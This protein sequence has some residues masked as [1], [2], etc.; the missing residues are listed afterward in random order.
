MPASLES[1]KVGDVLIVS[2]GGNGF[3]LGRVT[4][5]TK[6]QVLTGTSRWRKKD[7]YAVGGDTW[8][9]QSARIPQPGEIERLEDEKRRRG[10]CR[11]IANNAGN[12]SDSAL[13]TSE[14]EALVGKLRE[15]LKT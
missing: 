6:T 15:A 5:I 13:S 12:L 2:Y 8:S 4:K 7:G 11:W 3:H 14:L 10:L 1:A 9:V